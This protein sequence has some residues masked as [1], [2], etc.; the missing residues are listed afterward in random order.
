M[1]KKWIKEFSRKRI[2]I[3]QNRKVELE[4]DLRPLNPIDESKDLANKYIDLFE[5]ID[6]L[7]DEEA[8]FL[9]AIIEY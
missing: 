7:I 2:T 5:T 4:K 6:D 9:T 3:L 1:D 8:K